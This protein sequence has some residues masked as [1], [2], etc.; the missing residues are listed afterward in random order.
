MDWFYEYGG[1]VVGDCC[2][3]G[4]CVFVWYDVEVGCVGVEVV[5][6]LFVVV[7]VDDC[8]CVFV[9]VVC[10]DDDVCFVLGDV[11]DLVFL[12]MGDFDVGFDGFGIGVYW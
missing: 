3:D 6:C 11:F 5:V 1:C 2:C 9:E 10:C 4:F 12:G 8:G 7:E